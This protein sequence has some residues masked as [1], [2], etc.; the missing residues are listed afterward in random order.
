MLR[1]A[2]RTSRT[3]LVLLVAALALLAVARP[4]VA[5]AKKP[6]PSMPAAGAA[7]DGTDPTGSADEVTYSPWDDSASMADTMPHAGGYIAN[8]RRFVAQ[9]GYRAA[10]VLP[11]GVNLMAYAP[12]VGDQGS[13]G[14]CVAWTI[15]HNIMGYWANRSGGVDTPYAPLFLYM[16]NVAAGGAPNRGLNPDTVLANVQ[17]NGVDSQDDYFQGTSNYRVPPTAAHIDNARNYKISGGPGC[18]PAPAR[19]RTPGR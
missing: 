19:A 9:P 16:R 10:D 2:R 6:K 11:A 15:S 1:A 13:I 18:G 8:Q 5:A 17:A 4:A 3:L 12:P 7:A 14:A